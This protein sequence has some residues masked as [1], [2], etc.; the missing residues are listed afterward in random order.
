M[1][2]LR[3]IVV[4]LTTTRYHL[5]ICMP[6]NR[7]IFLGE[8]GRV[9]SQDWCWPILPGSSA[10]IFSGISVLRGDFSEGGGMVRQLI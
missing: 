8:T 4:I 6:G 9:L 10:A 3:I 2:R 1:Q 5:N 7:L